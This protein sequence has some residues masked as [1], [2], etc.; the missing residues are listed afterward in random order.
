MLSQLIECDSIHQLSTFYDLQYDFCYYYTSVI[1]SMQTS[2]SVVE[3]FLYKNFQPAQ[4]YIDYVCPHGQSWIFVR[5]STL[6]DISETVHTHGYF[7]DSPHSGI[8]VRQPTL[9]DICETVH[10]QGYLWDSPH[11][12]IFVRQPTLRDISE[13]AHTQGY[14]WDSPH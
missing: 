9:R 6:R 13:T 1:F 11:S 4:T 7:W 8:F 10:T 5:Q 3:A 12:G 2:H 14:F